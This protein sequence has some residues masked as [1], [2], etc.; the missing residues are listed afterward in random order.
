MKP[1]V[2]RKVAAVGVL[3]RNRQLLKVNVAKRDRYDEK[4]RAQRLARRNVL[5]RAENQPAWRARPGL[6]RI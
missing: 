1:A 3:L 2:A 5:T 4:P 6:R